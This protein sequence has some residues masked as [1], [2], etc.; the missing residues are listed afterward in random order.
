MTI[1]GV[2]LGIFLLA[3]SQ[4]LCVPIFLSL[5]SSPTRQL[6]LLTTLLVRSP[7]RFQYNLYSIL[8]NIS[9]FF[10][11]TI[12]VKWEQSCTA[13]YC[14]NGW[15]PWRYLLRDQKYPS[16]TR[17]MID[18][19]SGVS[20]PHDWMCGY[21]TNWVTNWRK[22]NLSVALIALRWHLWYYPVS[23]CRSLLIYADSAIPLSFATSLFWP[24]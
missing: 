5:L 22:V 23:V 17:D 18:R 7:G 10:W 4:D 13:C 2:C 6:R 1:W 24:V 15:K 3:S 14:R 19:S 16:Q 11:H 9:I 8:W 20:L 21:S 12:N